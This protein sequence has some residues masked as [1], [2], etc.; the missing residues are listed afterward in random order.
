MSGGAGHAPRDPAL[1][2]RFD[3]GPARGIPGDAPENEPVPGTALCLSGGGYRA[4][5]FHLGGLWRLNELGLLSGLA[6]VSA[7]SGGAIAAAALAVAWP[8][9]AF[10]DDGV[11]T[12]LDD[13]VVAPLRALASRT[14][15]A[16][17]VVLGVLLPGGANARLAARYRRRLLGRRTLADLPET[18]EF[19]FC[20]TDLQSGGLW[21]FSRRYMADFRVG[22]VEQPDLELAVVLAASSA[23]P[24][25]LSPSLLRLSARS[26]VPGSGLDLQHEPFTTKPELT[27]GGVYDNLALEAAFKRYRTVLVSDAGRDIPDKRRTPRTWGLA[28]LRITHVIDNQVRELRKQRLLEAYEEDKR[29]GAYWSIRSELD[30]FPVADPLPSTARPQRVARVDPDSAGGD[31]RRAPGTT[32][33]LGLRGRRRRHPRP[34]RTRRNHR[35]ADSPTPTRRRRPARGS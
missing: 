25:F 33:Q 26:Y 1:G 6:R 27:D 29:E 4:M 32:D 22:R 14:L 19:V 31:R 2:R 18:P 17:A 7:V 11:A 21:L 23:F 15:D 35:R 3:R 12:G 20:A 30:S 9:L 5:L 16:P 13:R 10:G 8:D 34:R 24:P 28:M